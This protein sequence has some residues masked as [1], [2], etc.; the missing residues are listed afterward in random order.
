MCIIV[1][2]PDDIARAALIDVGIDDDSPIVTNINAFITSMALLAECAIGIAAIIKMRSN[3]NLNT[4]LK[5]SFLVS[6][7]SACAFSIVPLIFI[8]LGQERI[9]EV[10]VN[11][12]RPYCHIPFQ[13]KIGFFIWCMSWHLF[14]ISLYCILVL[15]L[16]L[17]FKSSVYEMSVTMIRLFVVIILLTCIC[18]FS[19]VIMAVFIVST[20]SPHDP[21]SKT[22]L[23]FVQQIP[24]TIPNHGLIIFFWVLVISGLALFNITGCLSMFY[25]LRTILKLATE[26]KTAGRD[27][28]VTQYAIKLKGKYEAPKSMMLSTVFFQS[29]MVCYAIEGLVVPNTLRPSI[30]SIEISINLLCAY[31][32][33]SFAEKHY[34]QCCRCCDKKL[35]GF[36]SNLM[37]RNES[38][39]PH[40]TERRAGSVMSQS[41]MTISGNESIQEQTTVYGLR[42]IVTIYTRPSL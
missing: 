39:E 12:E 26:Q 14:C 7:F 28:N 41:L 23:Y 20:H 10:M 11:Y 35:R 32:Q 21:E 31:F 34:Q 36:I 5:V 27:L 18:A 30:W 22:I 29:W 42:Q 4:S 13:A 16:Y 17:S 8:I 25:L 6:L 37:K 3:Q 15:K 40:P 9:L 24:I 2:V 33:F 1:A 38:K 19:I